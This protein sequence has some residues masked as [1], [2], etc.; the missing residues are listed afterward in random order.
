M[1]RGACMIGRA[2]RFA[3]IAIVSIAS[4]LG[5][6]ATPA[7]AT[8]NWHKYFGGTLNANTWIYTG[9]ISTSASQMDLS[10]GTFPTAVFQI[11]QFNNRILY[12]YGNGDVYSGF[13]WGNY[14]SACW[15]RYSSWIQVTDCSRFANA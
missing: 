3:V 13:N 11:D 4:L 14:K 7:S 8:I 2:R 1:K 12:A 15:N 5:V 9:L 6:G 10:K